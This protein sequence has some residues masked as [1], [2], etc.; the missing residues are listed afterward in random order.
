MPEAAK[1]KVFE[2]RGIDSVWYA[3]VLSD[4]EE[5]IEFDTPKYLYP[6]AELGKETEASSEAPSKPPKGE[7]PVRLRAWRSGVAAVGSI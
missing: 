2:F 4:T 6:V 1:S 5:A 7:A 3:K